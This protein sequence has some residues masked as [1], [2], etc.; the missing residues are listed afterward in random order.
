MTKPEIIP[1]LQVLLADH[2]V[3][4]QKLRGYHWNVRGPLFFALHAKF[5]ELYLLTADRVDELAERIT[6]LGDRPVSTLAGQLSLARLEEDDGAP[7]ANEMVRAILTDLSS[8]GAALREVTDAAS[9]AGDQ[10]T[11]NMLEGWADE[12]EKTAWMLRAFLDA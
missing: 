1:S 7:S 11:A 9:S 3:L 10:A 8:V 2:Q 4:Y 6:A 5:E 12:Q